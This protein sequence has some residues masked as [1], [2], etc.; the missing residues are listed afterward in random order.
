MVRD[1]VNLPNLCLQNIVYKLEELKCASTAD[2]LSHD[3]HKSDTPKAI[4]KGKGDKEKGKTAAIS[5]SGSRQETV[6]LHHS[7]V[8]DNNKHHNTV[9]C[10][11]DPILCK[12]ISYP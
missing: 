5:K 1:K 3:G 9:N 10:K 4:R 2:T 7:T 8:T 12:Y 11:L 6:I